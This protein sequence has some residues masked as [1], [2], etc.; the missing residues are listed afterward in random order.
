[1]DAGSVLLAVA[2]LAVC[3]VFVY[4]YHKLMDR[5]ITLNHEAWRYAVQAQ[6][7]A[8]NRMNNERAWATR[9]IETLTQWNAALTKQAFDSGNREISEA[10]KFMEATKNELIAAV[11]KQV[12]CKSCA[13]DSG[14]PKIIP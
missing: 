11:V 10:R 12:Q 7:D 2:C 9:S 5:A 3:T 14:K 1:M 13:H 6:D 8:W 4:F